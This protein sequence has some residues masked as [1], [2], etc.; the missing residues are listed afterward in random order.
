MK[1]LLYPLLFGLFLLVNPST[2]FATHIVGGEMNYRCLGNNMYEI[3][4]TVFRDCYTGIP[5]FDDPASIGIFSYN[6]ITDTYS[7]ATSLGTSGQLLVPSINNDTLNPTL[8]NPCLVVPPDVCVNT[9]TYTVTANLPFQTGGYLLAYQRCCRNES[10]LNIETPLDVGAT[11]TAILSE[12]TLLEC[13]SNAVFN[14]WPP[15][16]ICVNEPIDFDHSATDIDGDSLV[17]RLCVPYTGASPDDPMPQPPNTPPFDEVTWVDPPYNLNNVMGGVPLSID[18]E[19]GFLTG[20]PN[21]IG[22]FVVGICVDEYRNGELISTTR[23]DFQYNVGLCG[24]LTSAFFVPEVSCEGL[25]VT[26]DNQSTSANNY[27]WYFNDPSNPNAT[28]SQF[29]P[30]YTYSDTGT[31]TVML[32]AEANAATCADTAYATFSIYEP[33]LTSLFNYGI[34]N[35]NNNS[36]EINLINQ[37]DDTVFDLVAWEWSVNN[38]PFSNSENPPN[39]IGNDSNFPITMSLTVTNEVGCQIT[40]EQVIDPINAAFFVPEISCDGLEVT[41]DNQGSGPQNY[42]WFFND[43]NNPGAT[44]SE[45]EPTYTYSDTGTYTVMLVAGINSFTCTDTAYASFSLYEPSLTANFNS[46][47]LSC[48]DLIEFELTNLS[49]DTVFNLVA[50]EWTINNFPFSTNENP[51]NVLG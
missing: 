5:D 15:I 48:E 35:C 20:T 16:Y 40:Y 14:A 49:N 12:E 50:W 11:Y 17:Y 13:N 28:S 9:T 31:Y 46:N 38:I 24:T 27:T 51:P 43:P 21:T 33:S 29:E 36:I 25:N 3:K 8:N 19:T 42:M 26:F 18:S 34:L 47:L 22:Q 30:T 6:P 2:V 39:Y 37:S 44:S 4:L 7:L 23:R 41:F 10:I 45:F 32:V 1:N